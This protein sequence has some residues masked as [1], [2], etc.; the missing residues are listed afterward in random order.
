MSFDRLLGECRHAGGNLSINRDIGDSH[1]LHRGNERP[2]FARMTI[3]K[4]FALQRAKILHDRCLA[5][6]TEMIL[7]FTRTWR[8]AFFPLFVLNEIEDVFLTIC[9]HALSSP[10]PMIVQ[11]QMNIII[12]CS[13]GAPWHAPPAFTEFRRGGQSEAATISTIGIVV[14]QAE[15]SSASDKRIFDRAG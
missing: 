12:A 13:H 11:V 3:D 4:T 5:G 2:G 7:D 6:E 1:F 14:L 10:E 9:Q 8:D 15:W